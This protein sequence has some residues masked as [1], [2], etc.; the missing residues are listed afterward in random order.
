[1]EVYRES[2]LLL[3]F[4][5]KAMSTFHRLVIRRSPTA[6]TANI[7]PIQISSKRLAINAKGLG[8]FASFSS[9]TYRTQSP[10]SV[11]GHM[12]KLP[13]ALTRLSCTDTRS[14]ICIP[15]LILSPLLVHSHL[16]KGLLIYLY[17]N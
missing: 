10:I 17:F 16:L 9:P 12:V 1:M 3:K 14:F 5:V 11:S 15:R 13:Q 7:I 8:N 6:L 2:L 4:K